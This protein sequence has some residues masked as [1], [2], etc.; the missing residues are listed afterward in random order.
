MIAGEADWCKD[1][2]GMHPRLA[3]KAKRTQEKRLLTKLTAETI[4]D[5]AEADPAKARVMAYFRELVADG[6]AEWQT[7]EN[8]TIQLCF[9]TGEIYLLEK[10]TITRTA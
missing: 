7:L 2:S 1:A 8:G 9:K 5:F 10:T 4:T 3:L 6:L